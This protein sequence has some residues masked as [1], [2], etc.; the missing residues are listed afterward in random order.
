MKGASFQ[1]LDD[2]GGQYNPRFAAIVA[3]SGSNF[4]VDGD[5]RPDSVATLVAQWQA[6]RPYLFRK[7][8]EVVGPHGILLA[9]SGIP[10]SPDSSL[11]GITL[12]AESC[13]QDEDQGARFA[14]ER[15]HD[16]ECRWTSVWANGTR[17]EC[18]KAF[19][20][21]AAVSA[22]PSMSLY[23]ITELHIVPLL[24]QCADIRALAKS[25]PAVQFIEG[26]DVSDTAGVHA[27]DP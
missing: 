16:N 20:G 21:Q 3:D 1:Y 25:L 7:L 14:L 10:H 2:A 15:C 8:R 24:Q 22:S 6:F 9:N 5:G 27:C 18:L 19:E 23:W 17:K 12:E 4:D 26:V 13:H 11:S